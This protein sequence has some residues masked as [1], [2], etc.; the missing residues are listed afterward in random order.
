MKKMQRQHSQLAACSGEPIWRESGRECNSSSSSPLHSLEVIRF[1]SNSKWSGEKREEKK[2]R[3]E[4]EKKKISEEQSAVNRF[5][6]SNCTVLVLL[7]MLRACS[8][9]GPRACSSKHARG[10]AVS[11]LAEHAM[12]CSSL[13]LHRRKKCKKQQKNMQKFDS[14]R[15]RSFRVHLPAP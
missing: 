7:S 9:F 11:M 10:A 8:D 3:E 12:V 1:D 4:K 5:G 2:L 14:Q 6:H 13:T 15:N